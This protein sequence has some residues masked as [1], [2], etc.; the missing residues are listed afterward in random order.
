MSIQKSKESFVVHLMNNGFSRAAVSFSKFMGNNIKIASTQSGIARPDDLPV[1]V[2]GKGDLYIIVTQVIG[3]LSGKSY[4][5][6]NEEQSH[7]LTML[8]CHASSVQV[9]EQMKEAVLT[10][11]DNIISAAVISELSEGLQMEIYGDVP[12]LKRIPISGLKEFISKENQSMDT[13][14]SLICNTAFQLNVDKHIHPQFIWKLSE[15]IFD[16]IPS[17]KLSIR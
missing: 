1:T 9:N 7:S 4:L 13:S 17:E 8:A 3:E 15:K 12:V 6:F 11:I 2:S 14:A 5:I 10:E 16:M